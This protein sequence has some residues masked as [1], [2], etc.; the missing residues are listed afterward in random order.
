MRMRAGLGVSLGL[1][2]ALGAP[3]CGGGSQATGQGGHGGQGGGGGITIDG[4]AGFDGAIPQDAD[5]TNIAWPNF[6]A[7]K[8]APMKP[9]TLEGP[10][11]ADTEDLCERL[12]GDDALIL[13]N[14]GEWG[15]G[16]M[17][18]VQTASDWFDDDT[19]SLRLAPPEGSIVRITLE[20]VDGADFQPQGRWFFNGGIG[21]GIIWPLASDANRAHQE[22]LVSGAYEVQLMVQDRRNM[23]LGDKF[24]AG[25]N[26]RVRFDLVEATPIDPGPLPVTKTDDFTS[27]G[28]VRVYPFTVPNEKGRLLVD[29]VG[30]DPRPSGLPASGIATDVMIYDPAKQKKVQL[31]QPSTFTTDQH[32]SYEVNPMFPTLGVGPG[33]YWLMV[34][35]PNG[36]AALS[37]TDYDLSVKFMGMPSNDTCTGAIDVT[38]TGTTTRTTMGDTTFAA[39]D[40][41]LSS[42]SSSS[43]CYAATLNFLPLSGKDVMYSVVVPARKRLTATVTPT[44]AASW[45][46]GIWLSTACAAGGEFSCVAS[47]ASSTAPGPQTVS[48]TNVATSDRTMYV[49]VDSTQDAGAFTLATSFTDGPAAPPNDTCSGAIALDLTS[50]LATI[51][52][53]TTEGAS[54]DYHPGVQLT[55]AACKDTS[56]YYNGADV[57]YSAVVPA[58]KR[59]SVTAYPVGQ[60]NPALWISD[61]CGP[62]AE[63]TC[64]AARDGDGTREN[65]VWTNTGT[66][67]KPVTI[68]VDAQD[69][70]GGAFSLSAQLGA[71]KACPSTTRD[72]TVAY[73]S[74]TNN[75]G[76]D[77]TF[78]SSNVS[79]VCATAVANPLIGDE[80]ITAF[81]VPAGKRLSITIKSTITV[82]GAPVDKW[83]GLLTTAC[84]TVTESGAACVAAGT[85][86]SWM[87]TDTATRRVYL[88]MDLANRS[89]AQA[90]Y[91][92]IPTLN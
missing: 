60:F 28:L 81:D 75:A 9:S 39:N 92:V 63:A 55:S 33:S 58:G 25:A 66:A 35:T 86:L 71:P 45:H 50:G 5:R 52:S 80:D 49:I 29:I 90:D 79:A 31:M 72:P 23:V 6:P 4:G 70:V 87:N 42:S 77:F 32:L 34:D 27:A 10:G 38:P 22:V 24:G 65:V 64:L 36:V 1:A 18:I 88:F 83:V 82:N 26:Y 43:A 41:T 47:A 17:G 11:V 74:R 7:G 37:R 57:V 68:H 76:N 8:C 85:S 46:P 78:T 2:A 61:T 73:V 20:A 21:L 13:L 19:F 30:T 51:S 44:S 67:D 40:T 15:Y 48:W 59:L 16:S 69:P 56:A 12:G 14:L 53:A 91:N 84:G 62:N 89:P 3:A 54:D